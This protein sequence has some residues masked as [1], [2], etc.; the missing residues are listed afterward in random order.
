M[1]LQIFNEQNYIF[2][3]NFSLR[4]ILKILK[5][6][7]QYSYKI[8]FYRKQRVYLYFNNGGLFSVGVKDSFTDLPCCF[9]LY[10]ITYLWKFFVI[11]KH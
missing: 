6:Q 7:P 3:H 8:Y 10:Y 11:N 9:L 5:F 1:Y 2:F 4:F